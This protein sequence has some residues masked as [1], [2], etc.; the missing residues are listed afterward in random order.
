VGGQSLDEAG[1]VSELVGVVDRAEEGVRVVG[2]ADR[3]RPAR[4][5]GERRDE[6][7]VDAGCDEHPGG[8][9][10]V[11]AGVEVPGDGDA[12]DGGLDVGIVEHDHRGL[13][14]E[15]EVHALDVLGGA[16]RDLGARAHRP[17]DGDE[18]RASVLDEHPAGLPVAGDD[19]ERAGREEL[20][21]QLGEQQGGLRGGVEGLRTTVLPAAS[22]G[23]SSRPP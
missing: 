20:R 1:D 23:R 2:E 16:G 22:A 10:A 19:V 9:R 4:V 7:V 15:L 18:S 14:T 17:G 8:G 11:L 3:G 5:L 21:G 6:V 13:A 12:L